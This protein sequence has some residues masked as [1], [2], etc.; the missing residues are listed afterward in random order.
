MSQASATET[1]PAGPVRA[2]RERLGQRLRRALRPSNFLV[3]V[4]GPI[5]QKDMWISGRKGGTYWMRSM[6]GTAL[7]IVVGLTFLSVFASLRLNQSATARLQ[8]MQEIAPGTTQVIIWFQLIALS[9]A[10]VIYGAPTICEEKRAGTLS[11]LLTT[12]LKAWQIVIGKTSAFFVQ[13]LILTL[14]AAPL[15]LAVRVFGGV[16]AEVIVAGTCL[17]LSTALLAGLGGLFFSIGARRTPAAVAGG[18]LSIVVLQAMVPIGCLMITLLSK[19]FS[20]GI[21]VPRW[22]YTHFCTP[23]AMGFVT[24]ESLSGQNMDS[25]IAWMSS[26]AY[27]LGLCV[28]LVL[29]SSARL[30]GVL[31]REGAGGAPIPKGKK[32]KASKKLVNAPVAEVSPATTDEAAGEPAA[33]PLEAAARARRKRRPTTAV[34]GVVR[35]VSNAPVL[36]RETRQPVFRSRTQL[37]LGLVGAGALLGVCYWSAGIDEEN[38]HSTLSVLGAMI[39]LLSAAASTTS[40]I[41]GEREARTWE[42]LITTPLSAWDIVVGKAAGAVRRQWF[43]PLILAVHFLLAV[44][45]SLIGGDFLSPAILV[46]LPL[47]LIPPVVFL[48]CSGTLLSLLCKKSVTATAGNMGIALLL[49][50]IGP[51]MVGWFVNVFFDRSMRD[52]LNDLFS[53]VFI[54]NPVGMVTQAVGGAAGM[55]TYTT[56]NLFDFRDVGAPVFLLAC[57]GSAALYGALSW[58]ALWA[59]SR[60]LARQ[61]GRAR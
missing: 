36:W 53:V 42:A 5:F 46:W 3:A 8:A 50:A 38:L 7:L 18:L 60:T 12:P 28:L 15:L 59:A 17:G 48:C 35:E 24:I 31:A 44:V 40:S 25:R 58:V 30:R 14:A 57:L 9:M 19:K 27:T 20:L 33:S 55:N 26:T 51:L 56:Y 1:G 52:A 37:I 16:S 21:D 2:P 4:P 45:F 29:A 41:S 32:A 23:A 34:E 54:S 39:M 43:V 6:Y 61:T 22:A 47:I 10:G 49:W 11:T 13:V